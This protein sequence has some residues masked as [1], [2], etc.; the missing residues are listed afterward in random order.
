MNFSKLKPNFNPKSLFLIAMVVFCAGIFAVNVETASATAYYVRTDGSDNCNGL[1]NNSG[2]SGNCAWATIQKA[3][4][5]MLAGD[6]CSVQSGT[7]SEN[8]INFANH[9]VAIY[10]NGL[11]TIEGNDLIFDI[12]K[13]NITLSGLKITSHTTKTLGVRDPSI[14]PAIHIYQSSSAFI[15]NNV[16][17]QV[18]LSGFKVSNPEGGGNTPALYL[19]NSNN[20]VIKNNTL[21]THNME[22]A[23]IYIAGSTGN[24]ITQNKIKAMQEYSIYLPLS[25]TMSDY[26]QI[27]DTSNTGL[28]GLPI[29]YLYNQNDAVIDGV[30]VD[31]IFVAYSDNVTINNISMDNSDGITFA[32]VSNSQINNYTYTKSKVSSEESDGMGEVKI[33]TVHPLLLF[34]ANYNDITDIDFLISGRHNHGIFFLGSNHNNITNYN[35][36]RI[37]LVNNGYHG[38]GHNESIEMG[39]THGYIPGG[40]ESS[41]NRIV[42]ATIKQLGTDYTIYILRGC[43]N[44]YFGNI[45]AHCATWG[46]TEGIR[47]DGAD[48]TILDNVTAYNG[49][50]YVIRGS[51]N[52]KV[53]DSHFN[54][55]PPDMP[56]IAFLLYDYNPDEL[57]LINSTYE[58]VEITTT[59]K[60]YRQW[61]LD[62]N[63]NDTSGSPILGATVTATDKNGNEVFSVLTGD[64]GRIAK[65]ILTE[66]EQTAYGKT[67][68]IRNLVVSPV[69]FRNSK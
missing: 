38:D 40:G 55:V 42:N 27:I 62:I 56:D 43:D 10:G 60:L 11:P 52:T 47:V 44:N 15:E 66:Y 21:I 8:N 4:N 41:N 20:N 46:Y 2:I 13:S 61:Y 30:E 54:Q 24:T 17:S 25:S 5:T 32:Y 67:W 69:Q 50:L 45:I 3:A 34:H 33:T 14:V 7:Y 9:N 48:N 23:G 28:N 51:Y 49:N 57:Y 12:K 65:Q 63:V 59:G 18:G 37:N 68:F 39:V 64:D 22:S 53:Y 36:D 35:Y 1:Y 19:H 16:I 58:T 6:T 29:Y 31:Q 26:N